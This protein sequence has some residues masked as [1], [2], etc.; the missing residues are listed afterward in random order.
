M[1]LRNRFTHYSIVYKLHAAKLHF[2]FK[3]LPLISYAMF[4]SCQSDAHLRGK[5]DAKWR[6]AS[7][8]HSDRLFSFVWSHYWK[9]MYLLRTLEWFI[10]IILLKYI[11]VTRNRFLWYDLMVLPS[12]MNK[13]S[14]RW[15]HTALLQNFSQ[16]P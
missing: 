12:L 5:R 15:H 14:K 6:R 9:N 16:R 3:F 13:Y 10:G 4:E 11:E 8:Y 2:S 7:W 1:R